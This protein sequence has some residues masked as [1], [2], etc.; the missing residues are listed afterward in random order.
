MINPVMDKV[1][2]NFYCFLIEDNGTTLFC[3]FQ[4]SNSS[5]EELARAVMEKKGIPDIIGR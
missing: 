5:V 3:R 2:V 4:K 1:F